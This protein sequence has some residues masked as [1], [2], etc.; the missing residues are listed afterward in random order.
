MIDKE[1]QPEGM[2]GEVEFVPMSVRERLRFFVQDL[3]QQL[4][5]SIRDAIQGRPS[6]NVR[7]KK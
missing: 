7:K 5:S 1:S 2:P 6:S 4:T 3:G